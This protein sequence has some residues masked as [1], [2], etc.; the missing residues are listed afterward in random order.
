MPR[1][2]FNALPDLVRALPA[3]QLIHLRLAI[4]LDDQTILRIRR[5]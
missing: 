1:G 4:F 5:N 3:R 2:R